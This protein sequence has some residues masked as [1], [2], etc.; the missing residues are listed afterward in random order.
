M[1]VRFENLGPI[2]K[3]EID[4]RPLTVIIGPNNS[5]KTYVAYSIYGLWK[6]LNLGLDPPSALFGEP[7]AAWLSSTLARSWAD[8]QA[9]FHENLPQFFQDAARTVIGGAKVSIRRPSRERIDAW[10]DGRLQYWLAA[11]SVILDRPMRID[12][13]G[14]L[15][16]LGGPRRPRDRAWIDEASSYL[17]D[18]ALDEMFPDPFLLPAERNALVIT[19]KILANRRYRLLRR[20][21]REGGLS[22][23][24]RSRESRRQMASL[25]EQ[26]DVLYPEP[27]EHFLEFLE[28]VELESATRIQRPSV[29]EPFLRLADLVEAG[30]QGGSHVFFDKTALGGRELRVRVPK[31]PTIDLSLASS[32]IKQLAPYLLYLRHRASP[33]SLLIIDEPEMNLHPDTQVR[34]LES[35]AILVNLG[36]HVL[37][38]THSPYFV[39]HLNN[40]IQGKV[41]DPVVLKKQAKSLYLGDPRAFLRLDQV[42]AYEMRDF[43]LV[44]LQRPEGDLRWDTLSEPFNQLQQKF[45]A[46]HEAAHP[47]KAED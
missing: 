16:P 13:H 32:S 29:P 47:S 8:S 25:R 41:G 7:V 23:S 3:T 15:A 34:F 40:L 46:L 44:S 6:E 38:T 28:D 1:R 17:L 43:K 42:G 11:V 37:V 9:S 27:I 20:A 39:D 4:V 19:Y 5:G 36:V 22:E 14:K 30:V 33:G 31:G 12:S 35:L 10:I 45:F 2:K 26:G 18:L 24:G 21:A